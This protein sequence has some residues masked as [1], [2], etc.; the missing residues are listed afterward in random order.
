VRP[1]PNSN[2]VGN[3]SGG[4]FFRYAKGN[5]IGGIA[6]GAG[7]VIAFNGTIGGYGGVVVVPFNFNIPNTDS[8]NTIRGNSIYSNLGPGIDLVPFGV[9]PNDAGDA[10]DG[11]NN[12]QNFPV[13]T[14]VTPAG[15]STTIQGTLNSKAAA[16][17]DVDFYRSGVCDASGN[18]EGSL[19]VG[20]TS[21]TT[22]ASGDASFNVTLPFAL[23]P[24][25][26][27][28][29]TA[30]DS[31]GNTSEFSASAGCREVKRIHVSAAFF[32][33]IEFQETG[34][35]AYRAYKSAYGDATSPG[36][37][38][39]VPVIRL[40]EFLEDSQRIGQGVRVGIGDWQQQLEANKNAYALEFVRRQRFVD[41]YPLSMTA[42]A[43]V[44]K[45]DQNAGGALSA[46]EKSQLV[47]S[48]GVTPGDASKRAAVL[49]SVAED[50]DLRQAELNRAFVLMQYY[51]YLRRNPDDPQD[52]NFGGWK[53]WLDKLNSFGGDFV[54][55]EMVKA[56][57]S[58]DEYRKRFGQ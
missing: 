49:R 40:N 5:T 33:S 44:S 1:I 47:A 42:A 8:R 34:Y 58:S 48:L 35:F 12:L 53:F 38:G 46:S 22:N 39:T 23:S 32:L 13:I 24:G 26:V 18:G 36:V 29:A 3:S 20:T 28:T 6:P 14:S 4:V 19:F 43:F 55:A 7:N 45:L 56:F 50:A 30:T 27:V 52:A 25:Q 41:A 21:V 37:T 11:A 2:I 57:I 31:S 16:T 15:G 10:D 54:A 9:T 51:G 17:Y